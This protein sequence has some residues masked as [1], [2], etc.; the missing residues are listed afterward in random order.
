MN[1]AYPSLS[2]S[3]PL[4]S[5]ND[6]H[7]SGIDSKPLGETKATGIT[8]KAGVTDKIWKPTTVDDI[9]TS[10]ITDAPVDPLTH[11]KADSDH[12]FEKSDATPIGHS[13]HTTSRIPAPVETSSFPSAEKSNHTST[14][15]SSSA[16]IGQSNFSSI[17]KSK[18]PVPVEEPSTSTEKSGIPAVDA[19]PLEY[20]YE[21]SGSPS[22]D[23]DSN[24]AGAVKESSTGFEKAIHN[25][26]EQHHDTNTVTSTGLATEGVHSDASNTAVP[27]EA[28]RTWTQ[29]AGDTL[30]K[31]DG[32]A[33]LAGEKSDRKFESTTSPTSASPTAEHSG[34]AHESKMSHIKEKLK[35]KLHIGHK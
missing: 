27:G 7:T 12:P 21:G 32:I 10:I 34:V 30:S 31:A 13:S 22:K 23:S 4:G 19:A 1:P 6:A 14:E 35:D 20:R 33:G 11:E 16:P 29:R 28:N 25:P 17:D 24:E 8:D 15:H 3:R 26:T 2:T 9:S 5:S 18:I